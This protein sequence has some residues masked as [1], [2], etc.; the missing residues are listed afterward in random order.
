MKL[1]SKPSIHLNKSLTRLKSDLCWN[2]KNSEFWARNLTTYQVLS[3]LYHIG[4]KFSPSDCTRT[5]TLLPRPSIHLSKSL[6]RLKSDLFWNT[7]ASFERETWQR[8]KFF[9]VYH[10]GQKF[11]PP[12]SVLGQWNS[13]LNPQFIW[14]SPWL[15]WEAIYVEKLNSEF[16]A[17][18][19]TTYQVLFC[20]PPRSKNFSPSHCTRTVKLLSKPSIHLN[21]SLTRL[22]SDLCWNIK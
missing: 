22:K 21:K 3:F 20:I 2:T 9:F 4:Q 6:T 8:I 18:N 10:P 17:R 11:F 12:H 19:L 14:I 7:I 13:S 1:L 5:R 15:D 16:W